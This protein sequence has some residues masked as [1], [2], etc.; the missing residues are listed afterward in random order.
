MKFVKSK[1]ANINYLAKIIDIQ[2]FTPHPD[3]ETTKL[4]LAHVDGFNIVVGIDSEPGIYVYFPTSC[5]INPQ[6][7][8]YG[9]LYRHTEKNNEPETKAG[10][11]EDNGRVKAIKLRGVVSEGF[12][13]EWNIFNNFLIDNTLQT[14]E[15]QINTEFDSIKCG[16]KVLWIC[17][18]YIIKTEISHTAKESRYQKK[19]KKFNRVID[20]QFR[21]HY[22]TAIL[23][24]LVNPIKPDD[25]ISITSKIHGCVDANTIINTNLGKKTIKE[26]VDNKLNILIE[27]FDIETQQKVFVPIDNYYLKENDGDWYEIEL[28]NGQKIEITGN[29]PVWLPELNCYR[30]VDEL[31]EGDTVLFSDN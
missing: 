31:I 22:E 10:F 11:F 29:N 2:N 8:A 16:D 19:V 17:K 28:E 13:L 23:K 3:P 20:T 5:E 15:P 27:A 7:L 9:N 21:F 14:I 6:L 30:R 4:K 1:N 26:I 24:K 18:K 25:L 12:L